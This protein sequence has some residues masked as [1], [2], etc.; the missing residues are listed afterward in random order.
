MTPT[1]ISLVV[2]TYNERDNIRPL[3]EELFGVLCPR[4]DIAFELVIVDD[5]SPD[6]TADAVR[7]IQSEY[8]V[9]LIERDAERGLGASVMEGFAASRY[10]RVGVMD[11]DLSHD[12][13]VLPQMIEALATADLVVASRLAPGGTVDRWSFLRRTVSM[14]GTMLC[15]GLT[16]ISDPLSGFFVCRKSVLEPLDGELISPGYKILLEILVRGDYAAVSSIPYTFRLRRNSRS[17]LC[18]R[19]YRLFIRQLAA[20]YSQRRLG[21]VPAAPPRARRPGDSLTIL[22]KR[23]LS[24]D[25]GS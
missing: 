24:H 2:P 7:G 1:G 14:T 4:Q 16:D 12:P 22:E 17:K 8:P 9:G 21:R 20:F 13:A 11:G 5:R 25:Q 15:R 23:N 6:G 3:V 10:S 19:E 18:L